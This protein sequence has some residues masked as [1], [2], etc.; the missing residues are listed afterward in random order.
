MALYLTNLPM[1]SAMRSLSGATSGIDV[2]FQRLSSGLRINSAKDDPAGLQIANRMTAQINGLNQGARNAA[3]GQALAQTAEGALDEIT[4]MLQRIRVLANQ[5]ANGTNTERD[6]KALGSE[7][8]QLCQEIT[9]ISCKTTFGGA[10]ILCG[11]A[12]RESG[13]LLDE[14][15]RISLQVGADANDTIGID[16]SAGFSLS[17]ICLGAGHGAAT[18]PGLVFGEDEGARF[19]VSTA[20][21]A[22]AA[23]GMVDDFIAK[24]SEKRGELGAV[25]N[26]LD[27]VIRLNGTMA[28]NL[29][30]ARS[31]IRDTDYAEEVSNL[32]SLQAVQQVAMMMLKQAMASKNLIL[33]LL[34]G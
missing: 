21:N 30:D 29:S 1:M 5:A 3:D 27:S 28:T 4:S 16:L 6:R 2:C 14:Q 31:R 9:R 18:A 25:Q 32:T 7:V 23:L 15:G 33:S 34:Q 10:K 8:S 11:T 24:V 20:A 22:Q 13:G 19:S 26:R 12:N 17:A